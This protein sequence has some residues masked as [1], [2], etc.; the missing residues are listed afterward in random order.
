MKLIQG[1]PELEKGPVVFNTEEYDEASA[2]KLLEVTLEKAKEVIGVVTDAYKEEWT[3]EPSTGVRAVFGH[4][5]VSAK[6]HFSATI[7]LCEEPDLSV[8]ADVHYR[9]IFELFI[10]IRY[11]AFLDL[12]TKERYVMDPKNWTPT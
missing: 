2:Q 10:Q 5:L 12:A 8:V 4:W 6:R 11:Y 7:R 9:Q 3:T 1:I